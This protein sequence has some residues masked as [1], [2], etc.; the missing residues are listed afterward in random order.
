MTNL[1]FTLIMSTVFVCSLEGVP[2][3]F[4]MLMAFGW[5]IAALQA[6]FSL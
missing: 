2:R 1:Q 4:K 5:S 6:M 3:Y